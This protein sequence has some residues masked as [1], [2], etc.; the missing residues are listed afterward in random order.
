MRG[1]IGKET[2][3]SDPKPSWPNRHF[4]QNYLLAKPRSTAD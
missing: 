4:A 1:A 3:N 2:V